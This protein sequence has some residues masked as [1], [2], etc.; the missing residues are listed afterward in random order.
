MENEGLITQNYNPEDGPI[1]YFAKAKFNNHA[2]YNC[3]H[4]VHQAW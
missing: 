3:A 1:L 4:D 2:K